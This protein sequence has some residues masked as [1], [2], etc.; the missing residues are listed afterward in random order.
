MIWVLWNIYNEPNLPKMVEAA[1]KELPE[2]THVFV[3]GK[4]P[5]YPGESDFSDDTGFCKDAGIYLKAPLDECSKR[6]LGLREIDARAS[7]G[8]WVLVLDGD[9]ELMT[10]ELPSAPVGV[11]LFVRISDGVTY[12]RARLYKWKPGYEFRGRHYDLFHEDEHIATLDMGLSW[13]EVCGTGVH[14]DIRDTERD[15]AKAVYYRH[16]QDVEA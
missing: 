13:H 15:R 6:T 14:H 7:D 10:F 2:R 3:D 9:E 1:D 5:A 12:R 8:D 11:L 4:Y 16:L